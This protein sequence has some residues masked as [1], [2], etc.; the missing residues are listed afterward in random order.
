MPISW[1]ILKETGFERGAYPNCGRFGVWQA[2]VDAIAYSRGQRVRA[3]GKGSR[4]GIHMFV[5]SED[6]GRKCWL[7]IFYFPGSE[8]YEQTKGL[9]AG[10]RVQL[11]TVPGKGDHVT[12][13]SLEKQG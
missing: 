10:D 1:N 6:D 11:E 12:V 5:R 7:Y 4:A 13:K 2:T 9:K 8:V 3:D